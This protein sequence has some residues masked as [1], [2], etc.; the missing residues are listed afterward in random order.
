MKR[1]S[2]ELLEHYILAFRLS[3]M[4]S[5]VAWRKGLFSFKKGRKVSEAVCL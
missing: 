4:L 1:K 2:E 5:Y 3:D